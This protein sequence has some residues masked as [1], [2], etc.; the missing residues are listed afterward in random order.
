MESWNSSFRTHILS[1]CSLG[2]AISSSYWV[3]VWTWWCMGNQHWLIQRIYWCQP[4]NYD[5]L[6]R[7]LSFIISIGLKEQHVV[8]D[9]VV[10]HIGEDSL[11]NVLYPSISPSFSPFY[12]GC[13]KARCCSS[14]YVPRSSWNC[15]SILGISSKTM[16]YGCWCSGNVT[17]WWDL[18][19]FFFWI[20][21]AGWYERQWF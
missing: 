11:C 10:Y 3:W 7:Y 12:L 9:F 2:G 13:K 19:W 14:G 17:F 6:Q 5:S 18:C 1:L 15:W 16:G 21:M 8:L 4:G 20:T